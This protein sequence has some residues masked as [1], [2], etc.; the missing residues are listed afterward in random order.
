[1]LVEITVGRTA[2]SK[3]KWNGA[4]RWFIRACEGSDGLRKLVPVVRR[5][6]PRTITV[7]DESF[8]IVLRASEPRLRLGLLLARNCGL[9]LT[10]ILRVA[11][12][13]VCDGRIN[14]PTKGGTWTQVRITDEMAAVL[15]ALDVLCPAHDKPYLRQLGMEH[16]YQLSRRLH[17]TQQAVEQKGAWSF[18]DLRRTFAHRL[19][20]ST[21]DLR[22]VQHQL[23]HVSP[24]HTLHYLVVNQTKTTEAEM[25]AA[26]YVPQKVSIQ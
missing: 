2:A 16:A 12:K 25:L 6:Q 9:R 21:K 1:M 11:P 10:T 8:G 3:R 22:A 20:E 4:I 18:H 24:Q 26:S 17:A 23:A 14:V 13:H 15:R 5:A 7:T 19:Y